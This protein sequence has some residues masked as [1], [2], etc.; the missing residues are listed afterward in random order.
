MQ[1]NTQAYMQVNLSLHLYVMYSFL[2]VN[3][4]NRMQQVRVDG[5]LRSVRVTPLFHLPVTH[6]HK[7]PILAPTHSIN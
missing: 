6:Y 2:H 4:Y 7:E 5:Q 3:T 1:A